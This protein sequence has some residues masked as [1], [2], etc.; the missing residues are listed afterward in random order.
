MRIVYH[1]KDRPGPYEKR[2]YL[3]TDIPDQDDV[4][5]T[6]KGMVHEAPIAKIRVEPKKFKVELVKTGRVMNLNILI[7]NEGSEPL[8]ITRIQNEKGTNTYF[9][10]GK[11][12]GLVIGAMGSTG[13]NLAF[14]ANQ[15][16]PFVQVI[17]IES[18]ARNVLNGRYP[19]MII[20]ESAPNEVSN[21]KKL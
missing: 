21:E 12:G 14:L 19:I 4:V 9:E 1:T 11:Q 5:I 7:S 3:S 10:A 2:I 18:N 6:I 20:G 15:A 16:S 17:F 8:T 13:F